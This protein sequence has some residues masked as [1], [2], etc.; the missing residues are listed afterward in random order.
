VRDPSDVRVRLE[1]RSDEQDVTALLG[2]AFVGE[3]PGE[4][5][6]RL[7]RDGL[8]VPSLT[9]VACRGS[10]VIGTLM[11]SR[12]AVDRQG[13]RFEALNLTPFAIDPSCQG[14]GVGR[15][16]ITWVL[17]AAEQTEYPLVLLE[18][19][20][21][22]YARYGFERSTQYGIARPSARIPEPAFQVRLL[23]AHRPEL[24]HGVAV[25]PSIF[26]ELGAVGP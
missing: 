3:I 21:A 19:D 12:V 7:R 1:R 8:H 5:A 2:R 22:H 18:G 4:L 16:L 14:R 11:M 13:E 26:Y 10:H 25:Y 15:T 24:H 9:A 17:A 6:Q 20:P 23:P